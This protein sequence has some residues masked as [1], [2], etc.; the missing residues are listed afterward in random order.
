MYT[1]KLFEKFINVS[2]IRVALIK[3]K[4]LSNQQTKIKI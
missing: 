4:F 3:C 2:D 1:K